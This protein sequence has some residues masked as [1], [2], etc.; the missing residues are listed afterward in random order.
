MQWP[1]T[2]GSIW[3]HN[4]PLPKAKRA[5]SGAQSS[6]ATLTTLHS[7]EL[8]PVPQLGA[9]LNARAALTKHTFRMTQSALPLPP[10]MCSRRSCSPREAIR[11]HHRAFI[12]LQQLHQC[13]DD[14]GVGPGHGLTRGAHLQHRSTAT[15]PAWSCAGLS[16]HRH[17]PHSLD[18]QSTEL[19]LHVQAV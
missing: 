18:T 19:S 8:I 5:R 16:S 15:R 10:L 6:A 2:L 1:V 4:V 11:S 9:G 12:I 17:D 7:L 14:V 3:L 13:G